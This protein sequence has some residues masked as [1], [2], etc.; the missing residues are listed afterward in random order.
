MNPYVD[1]YGHHMGC[2]NSCGQEAELGVEC[3]TDGEV[4]P[5]EDD[6]NPED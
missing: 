5:Y 4:E 1:E 3:C 2:C 6:P